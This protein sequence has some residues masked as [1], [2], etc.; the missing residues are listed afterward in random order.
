MSKTDKLFYSWGKGNLAF[1]WEHV[2]LSILCSTGTMERPGWSGE[3]R[4]EGSQ[5]LFERGTLGMFKARCWAPGK[6][7]RGLNME[8]ELR[9]REWVTKG[10]QYPFLKQ[11]IPHQNPS[12]WSGF[13][14][15]GLA[16]QSRELQNVVNLEQ[17]TNSVT[18]SYPHHISLQEPSQC[19]FH[20]LGEGKES[21]RYWQNSAISQAAS[22]LIV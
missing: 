2:N 9:K 21:P 1:A 17:P 7:Q 16:F 19:S 15:W 4:R 11:A 13:F 20:W 10:N 6:V 8:I 22:T 3:G 12:L 18:E 14:S 5:E